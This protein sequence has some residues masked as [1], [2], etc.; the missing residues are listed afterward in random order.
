MKHCEIFDINDYIHHEQRQSTTETYRSWEC[1]TVL[2][3]A[4]FTHVV[5]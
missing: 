1:D 3:T 4:S 5:Y 2:M